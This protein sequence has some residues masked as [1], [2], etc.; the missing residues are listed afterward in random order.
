MQLIFGYCI[1]I[2]SYKFTVV[3]ISFSLGNV[4]AYSVIACLIIQIIFRLFK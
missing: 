3:G 4:L 2:L 1:Q